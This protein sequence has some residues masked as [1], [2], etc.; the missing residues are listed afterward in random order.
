MHPLIFY[1]RGAAGLYAF[2][3][4]RGE[5]FGSGVFKMSYRMQFETAGAL[6][7]M[8]RRKEKANERSA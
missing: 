2:Y 1:V 6:Y 8:E 7:R 3:R 5:I 4:G